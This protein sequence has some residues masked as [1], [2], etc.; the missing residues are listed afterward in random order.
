MTPRQFPITQGEAY[1]YLHYLER[2]AGAAAGTRRK[3]LY[4]ARRFLS[5]AF[6]PATLEFS[7]LRAETITAF[8]Q[9]ETTSRQ[10][11]GRKCPGSATRIGRVSKVMM[12][13][14]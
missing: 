14:I 6:S 10:G 8:V 1:A 12:A 11:A 2:T 13:S 3:Y 7:Q 4:F 5:F 9:K